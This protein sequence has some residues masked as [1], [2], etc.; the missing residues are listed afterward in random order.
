MGDPLLFRFGVQIGG[1]GGYTISVATAWYRHRPHFKFIVQHLNIGY[2]LNIKT[3]ETCM[4]TQTL[5]LSLK[6]HCRAVACQKSK[7]I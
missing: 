5:M 1:V 6:E 4:V 7:I 3:I 2:T